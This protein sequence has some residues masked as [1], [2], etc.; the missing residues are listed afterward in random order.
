MAKHNITHYFGE[1]RKGKGIK[2]TFLVS[3]SGRGFKLFG[4]KTIQVKADRK[5]VG[6]TGKMILRPRITDVKFIDA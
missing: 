3:R 4:I 5:I 2:K 1:I 6:S